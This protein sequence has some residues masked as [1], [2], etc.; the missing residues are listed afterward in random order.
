MNNGWAKAELASAVRDGEKLT[1]RVRFKAA[2]GASGRQTVYSAMSGQM[3]KTDFY[4][5]SGDKKYLILKDSADEPLAPSSL[6]LDG[7][8][9]QAGAW[10]ATFPAPPAGEQATLHMLNVE[11]LG[12]FTVP[13]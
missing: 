7:K 6:V 8:A 13:E 12:P 4:L 1:V 2:E 9:P 5:V 10:N 11:P 3:W